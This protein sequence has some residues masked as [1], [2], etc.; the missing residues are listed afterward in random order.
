MS[1]VVGGFALA[2]YWLAILMFLVSSPT[3]SICAARA[4]TPVSTASASSEFKT[5]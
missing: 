1:D 5:S 4:A 3:T 2:G